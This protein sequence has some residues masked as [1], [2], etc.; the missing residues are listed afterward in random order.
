[1][2]GRMRPSSN[3]HAWGHEG[4]RSAP[5]FRPLRALWHFESFMNPS[6][7]FRCPR[8]THKSLQHNFKYRAYQ[9]NH[10]DV[11]TKVKRAGVC[12]CVCSLYQILTETPRIKDGTKKTHDIR[13]Y[14][15]FYW[16][17]RVFFLSVVA[18]IHAR[19]LLSW[20]SFPSNH[21]SSG[22]LRG[23]LMAERGGVAGGMWDSNSPT[24]FTHGLGIYQMEMCTGT[25]TEGQTKTRCCELASFGVFSAV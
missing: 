15:S 7:R 8:F 4:L 18:V 17:E 5:L 11:K 6:V 19:D 25:R 10:W 24:Q 14:L 13:R 1:M 2:N 16:R 21:Q 3:V 20:S 22:A 9:W 12:V 23:L